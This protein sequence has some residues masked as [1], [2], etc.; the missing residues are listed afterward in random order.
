MA[1]P[2][3]EVDIARNIRTIEWLRAEL[4]GGMASLFRAMFKGSSELILDALAGIVMT[5][6]LLGR[7]LGISF[8]RLDEHLT[9]KLAEHIEEPHELE[10][11]FGDFSA[12][13]TYIEDKS[14]GDPAVTLRG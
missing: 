5:T 4:T 13:K 2:T 11:G 10:R 1:Q 12:L 7:R 3:G 6:Y 14:K 9:R 8:T